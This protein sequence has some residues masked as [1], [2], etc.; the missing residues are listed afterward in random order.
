V[1]VWDTQTAPPDGTEE[2]L[3][4]ELRFQAHGDCT[5]GIR[6]DPLNPPNVTYPIVRGSITPRFIRLK[7]TVL[8]IEGLKDLVY[9][10]QPH[11][12]PKSP[13]LTV[14]M[15]NPVGL[16]CSTTVSGFG[17]ANSRCLCRCRDDIWVVFPLLLEVA[18][19]VLNQRSTSCF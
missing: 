4:P 2:L 17:D 1:S 11:R 3:Q 5:N 13:Q 9:Q 8:G 7:L 6:Y 16:C 19:V 15:N 12:K 14:I 18:V 10:I